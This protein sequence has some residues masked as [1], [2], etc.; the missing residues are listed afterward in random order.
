MIF[1]ASVMDLSS[2]RKLQ[3]PTIMF[4]HSRVALVA[5][6]TPGFLPGLFLAE[7][8]VVKPGT[9]GVGAGALGSAGHRGAPS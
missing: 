9:A 1:F 5:F 2:A 7:A 4:L 8:A 3:R 6:V